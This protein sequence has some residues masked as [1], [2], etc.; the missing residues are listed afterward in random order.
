[1]KK[2]ITYDDNGRQVMAIAHL[3]LWVRRAK[4]ENELERESENDEEDN[5]ETARVVVL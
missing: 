3:T 1:L 5:N 2:F 4:N